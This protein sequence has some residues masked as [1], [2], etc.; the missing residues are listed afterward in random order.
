[1]LLK[2]HLNFAKMNSFGLTIVRIVQFNPLPPQRI[3]VAAQIY[4]PSQEVH[5]FKKIG[6]SDQT[7]RE[8]SLTQEYSQTN[9]TAIVRQSEQALLIRVLMSFC[10]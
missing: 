7:L 8:K 3:F 5:G 9:L 2:A 10:H 6:Q 1:M 4:S